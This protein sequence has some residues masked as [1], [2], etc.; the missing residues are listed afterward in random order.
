MSISDEN[1]TNIKMPESIS[2]LAQNP[3]IFGMSIKEN[4]LLDLPE[5]KERLDWAVKSAALDD[6]IKL[7]KDKLETKVGEQGQT[8]SGGQRI[9]LALARNLYRDS[10]LYLLDDP[11]SALDLKVGGFIMENTI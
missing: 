3:L 6:D 10:T 2:Y 5:N 9:R 7:L 8:L 1:K 4:I 11:L